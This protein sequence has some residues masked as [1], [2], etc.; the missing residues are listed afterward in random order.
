MGCGR[1]VGPG[2]TPSAPAPFGCTSPRKACSVAT[3]WRPAEHRPPP[4]NGRR[5]SKP[6]RTAYG[7]QPERAWW[8]STP[9]GKRGQ[10]V[11]MGHGRPGESGNTPSTPPPFGCTP[12]HQNAGGQVG[13]Q[14]SG[15]HT[16]WAQERGRPYTSSARLPGNESTS[17]PR[18]YER[19]RGRTHT[20]LG[21]WPWSSGGRARTRHARS[22]AVKNGLYASGSP[23]AVSCPSAEYTRDHRQEHRNLRPMAARGRADPGE[24]RHQEG[25]GASAYQ[26][27]RGGPAG[28]RRHAVGRCALRVRVA[29]ERQAAW[30]LAGGP[31]NTG[32]PES[33]AGSRANRRQAHTGSNPKEGS[34]NRDRIHS[35]AP[36]VH[37][38]PARI[39]RMR[40]AASEHPRTASAEGAAPEQTA[41]KPRTAPVPHGYVNSRR[42]ISTFPP[43][44][45]APEAP[46]SAE[47]Y[48][49]CDSDTTV[50]TRTPSQAPE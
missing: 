10:H 47:V 34:C 25:N 27:D 13:P 43:S 48:L 6:A 40:K 4:G 5:P 33:T 41:H 15:T 21:R 35:T 8:R 18:A 16:P 22:R 20:G 30:Q 29:P 46:T 28:S 37:M 42:S 32:R 31:P 38:A 11:R 50:T 12:Q 9:G 49:Q 36:R 19:H 39:L 7:Q 45:K 44:G 3:D 24:D 17:R 23:H 14:C 2:N 26:W 1:P